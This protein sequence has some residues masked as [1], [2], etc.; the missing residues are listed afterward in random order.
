MSVCCLRRLTASAR[1]TNLPANANPP[2]ARRSSCGRASPAPVP[3]GRPTAHPAEFSWSPGA[4][5]E[6]LRLL[7]RLTTPPPRTHTAAADKAHELPTQQGTRGALFFKKK[8]LFCVH[9]YFR[10]CSSFH[11]KQAGTGLPMR[12]CISLFQFPFKQCISGMAKKKK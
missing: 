4:I 10:S 1:P 7:I 9:F 2:P 11:R 6:L 12:F 8:V 3:L 5:V